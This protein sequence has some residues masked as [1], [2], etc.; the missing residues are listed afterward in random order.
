M[1]DEIT[2]GLRRGTPPKVNGL[3]LKPAILAKLRQ[4][5]IHLRRQR[6]ALVLHVAERRTDEH[7]NDGRRRGM[8]VLVVIFYE[9]RL[10]NF[11]S[12]AVPRACRRRN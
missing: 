9:D 5:G 8:E 11:P 2:L 12:G 4:P 6:I 7:A 3:E 1:K 10:K